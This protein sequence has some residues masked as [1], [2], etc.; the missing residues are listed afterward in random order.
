MTNRAAASIRALL[1]RTGLLPW[2]RELRAL[3]R[4]VDF[5]PE[6]L[7]YWMGRRE[8]LPV[9]PLRLI[10]LVSGQPDIPWFLEGGRRAV[11]SLREALQD[12]RVEIESLATF[13]DFG[14]GCGRV[15]R[16]W[17]HLEGEIYG[18]DLNPLLVDWCRQ[19]LG[20]AHFER[21]GLEPPLPYVDESF[22]LVYALS[23]FTHLPEPLQLPWMG[24]MR[25]VLRPRG[26][27][28][29][30]THGARYADT[31]ARPEREAFAAG[32]IV[33]RESGE[34]GRNLCGAY[35]PPQ[36]VRSTF[37]AGFEVV[38]FRAEGATGNPHQDLWVFRRAV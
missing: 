19:H 12:Q 2:A 5:L 36:Y 22:D 10:E 4:R 3:A 38:D 28:V 18:S 6:N 32:R 17:R 31:L 25:R 8:R 37:A 23:V 21:N 20:F 27:L 24:E 14:C 33:V 9:P 16:H 26:F 34:A 35:H 13:L 29:F 7:H 11:A 15:I 1:R 30:S